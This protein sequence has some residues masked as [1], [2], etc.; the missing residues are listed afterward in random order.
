MRSVRFTLLLLFCVGWVLLLWSRRIPHADTYLLIAEYGLLLP[1]IALTLRAIPTESSGPWV[2]VPPIV[3]TAV[4]FLSLN[5]L[6]RTFI[7]QDVAAGDEGAYHFQARLFASGRVAAEAP[8]NV[9]VGHRPLRDIFR[10]HHHVIIGD[11]WLTQYPPGWPILLSVAWRMRLDWLLNPLLGLWILVLTW[12]IGSRLYN[13]RTGALAAAIAACSLSFE[14]Q[15]SGFLSHPSCGAFVITAVYFYVRVREEGSLW[16]Y[17]IVSLLCIAGASFIRPYTGFCAGAVLGVLLFAEARKRAASVRFLLLVVLVGCVWLGTYL[18]YNLYAYGRLS[19]YS[20]AGWTVEKIFPDSPGE[21]AESIFTYTRWSIQST[22]MYGF[23]FLLP[24]AVYPLV[25]DRERRFSAW[26]LTTLFGSV[27]AGYTATKLVSG[28][29]FG[30]RYYYEMYFALCLLAARGLLLLAECRPRRVIRVAT[31]AL[32]IC[33]AA[34]G[35]HAFLYSER[36]LEIFAPYAA[37]RDA[38]RNITEGNSVVYLP[39]ELGRDINLNAPEWTDAPH[40]YLEDPGES[41][42]APVAEVL[43]RRAWYVVSYDSVSRKA[44]VAR[45]GSR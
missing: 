45:H 2:P 11:R 12:R 18:G 9:E 20:A 22:M 39:F 4:L 23:P 1:A 5:L 25:T 41:L 14:H 17:A 32:V 8:A 42:R 34:Y 16:R 31:P 21:V 7:T 40:V 44:S 37:I 24:L 13:H 19:S 6:V 28:T 36:A 38:S 35:F 29:Y 30:E 15:T 10:F 27:A 26:V 3:L 43:G 33:A